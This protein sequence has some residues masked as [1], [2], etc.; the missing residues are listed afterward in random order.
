MPVASYFGSTSLS[1]TTTSFGRFSSKSS[2]YDRKSLDMENFLQKNNLCR[3]RKRQLR[4]VERQARG[5]DDWHL[6]QIDRACQVRGFLTGPISFST[7]WTAGEKRHA[8]IADPMGNQ[9]AESRR[10]VRSHESR[11][12]QGRRDPRGKVR[13]F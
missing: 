5:S 9:L 10:A 13:R 4:D 3:D 8:E 6:L 2:R 1:T 11:H 12:H 7:H